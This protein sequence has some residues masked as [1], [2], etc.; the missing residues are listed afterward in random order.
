MLKICA[1]S[2][3]V[4]VL[5]EVM[6]VFV[7]TWKSSHVCGFDS[8]ISEA[9]TSVCG[10][11]GCGVWNHNCLTSRVPEPCTGVYFANTF[12]GEW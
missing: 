8:T 11:D 3:K 12:I 10:G 5:A 6:R 9:E 7:Y 4:F 1:G 2:P